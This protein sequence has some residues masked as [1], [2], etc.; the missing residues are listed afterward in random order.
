MNA[1][2]PPPIQ[3]YQTPN[4][5]LEIVVDTNHDNIWLTQ[6]QMAFIF[7]VQI[8]AISKHIRNIYSSEELPENSTVSILEIVQKEGDRDIDRKSVV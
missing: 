2:Q 3:L 5:A 4:G 6:D 8:P 1:D 7:D